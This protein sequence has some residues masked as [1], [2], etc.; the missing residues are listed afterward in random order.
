[1]NPN[2][3]H[4]AAEQRQQ[5]VQRL[6]CAHGFII[7]LDCLLKIV[8]TAA[9]QLFDLIVTA[10]GAGAPCFMLAQLRC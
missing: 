1:M 2:T 7:V 10:H 8:A 5:I 6:G 9:P 3:T 4:T